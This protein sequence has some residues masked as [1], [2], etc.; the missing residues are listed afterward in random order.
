[1]T[2]RGYTPSFKKWEDPG[3]RP[4]LSRDDTHDIKRWIKTQ[5]LAILAKNVR[6]SPWELEQFLKGKLPP[7]EVMFRLKDYFKNK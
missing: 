7:V 5:D 4:V 2:I 6:C 1:M 3:E